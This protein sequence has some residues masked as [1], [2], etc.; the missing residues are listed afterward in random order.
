MIVTAAW[1]CV[2]LIVNEVACTTHRSMR[3]GIQALLTCDSK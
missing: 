3:D 2:A 1:M